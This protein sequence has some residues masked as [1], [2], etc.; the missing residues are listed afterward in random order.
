MTK[1]GRRTRSIPQTATK[2]LDGPVLHRRQV[3]VRQ[4]LATASAKSCVSVRRATWRLPRRPEML[5]SFL[6]SKGEA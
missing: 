4:Q 2:A 3:G 5:D 6:E 1:R